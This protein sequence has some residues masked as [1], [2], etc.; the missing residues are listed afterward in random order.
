MKKKLLALIL[1]V[2]AMTVQAQG[3][4]DVFQ[5]KW[6]FNAPT[7]PYGYNEGILNFQQKDGKLTAKIELP[8]SDLDI[9]QLKKEKFGY[10]CSEY[11]EGSEVT[12]KFIKVQ[13][14]G[15][16]GLKVVAEADGQVIDV[17]LKR[18]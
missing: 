6:N 1:S 15:E 8:N 12:I 2:F 4:N 3:E 5:G 10:S 18:K 16:T 7:A 11:I 9:Q 14:N 13:E 17:K